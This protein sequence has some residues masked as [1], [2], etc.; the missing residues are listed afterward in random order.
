MLNYTNRVILNLYRFIS[1]KVF[2]TKQLR[3][4]KGIQSYTDM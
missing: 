1:T 2:P 3:K 4:H